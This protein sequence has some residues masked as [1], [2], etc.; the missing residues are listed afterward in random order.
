[1]LGVDMQHGGL[2]RRPTISRC[3]VDEVK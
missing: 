2:T 3:L 1:V